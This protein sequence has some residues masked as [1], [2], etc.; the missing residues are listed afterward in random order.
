MQWVVTAEG[1][2]VK[3]QAA[4]LQRIQ[5]DAR[6]HTLTYK[7]E[8]FTQKGI[9]SASGKISTPVFWHAVGKRATKGQMTFQSK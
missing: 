3:M 1:G 2:R 5:K 8:I 6:A 7:I 9:D 4:L